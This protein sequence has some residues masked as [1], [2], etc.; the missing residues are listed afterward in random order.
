MVKTQFIVGCVS[1]GAKTPWLESRRWFPA[2]LDCIASL[3][4]F[5]SFYGLYSFKVAW[6]LSSLVF[7]IHQ[8]SISMK[9]WDAYWYYGSFT[10]MSHDFSPYQLDHGTPVASFAAALQGLLQ[11]EQRNLFLGLWPVFQ[12]LPR[13]NPWKSKVENAGKSTTHHPWFRKIMKSWHMMANECKW[14]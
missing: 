4:L 8:R 5:T 10:R 2:L 7:P 13:E 1:W 6:V 12:H 3:P 9:E 11:S 14:W